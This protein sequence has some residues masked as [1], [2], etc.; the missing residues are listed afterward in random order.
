MWLRGIFDNQQKQKA[1]VKPRLYFLQSLRQPYGCHLPLHKGG[2]G[3][4]KL[5][6]R[7]EKLLTCTISTSMAGAA[8]A[9]TAHF[10]S[11]N[12]LN[13]LYRGMSHNFSFR[14]RLAETK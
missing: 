5:H 13:E 7:E 10:K 2:L 14:I 11:P 12:S 8:G 6:V 1:R 9:D 4:L 3:L